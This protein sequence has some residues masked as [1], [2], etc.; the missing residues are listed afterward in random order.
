MNNTPNQRIDWQPTVSIERLRERAEVLA[1]IRAFFTERNVLE[2]E[3]PLLAN[4]GVTDLHL[5]NAVTEL[6]TGA[7]KTVPF[8]LQTSPEFAMKRLLAAGSGCIYQ[9]AK[10]V[11]NDEVGRFHNP[12]FTMLEWYRVG[13]TD[14]QLMD[15]IDAFL[16]QI[17]ASEPAEY[18]SYQQ[19]F[20]NQ[21]GND[22]L[23]K[24]GILGLQAWLVDKN[25]G[26]WVKRETDPDVLLQLAMSHFIEPTL[27]MQR[28]VFVYNFPASQA[29][30]ARLDANDKRVARRFEVY[31]QGVELANGFYEL[32]DYAQQR[33]RFEQ[34]NRQR[35]AMG[36]Q[37]AMIDERFLAALKFGLP[38]CA[39]VAL[40]V[41]RLLM[42]KWGASH[43]SEVV[44]FT[45]DRA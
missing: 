23:T 29:A 30:L 24:E 40:G 14:T 10:A 19:A 1:S 44:T 38:E 8:F 9:L 17:L 12:E 26:D 31:V 5:V 39:G 37:P 43:I 18:I 42:L 13:F 28:P 2:V 25:L 4:A 7:G 20:I 21:T 22:P 15:E 34:D 45:S 27:G 6:N 41:D 32:T 36:L 35:I 16:Q 33:A 3:T 11:R